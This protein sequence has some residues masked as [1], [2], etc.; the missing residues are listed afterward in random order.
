[1]GH[2]YS[3]DGS[4]RHTVPRTRGGGVRET[5]L[6]DARK[7]GLAPGVTDIMRCMASPGLERWKVTE[8]IKATQEIIRDDYLTE[9]AWIAD[10]RAYSQEEARTKAQIGTEIHASIEEAVCTWIV[11]RNAKIVE[12]VIDV[13]DDLVDRH[14]ISNDTW[15][16]EQSFYHRMDGDGM[17]YGGTI[18]LM[19]R[20]I[21]VDIKTKEDIDKVTLYDE[22]L[23][24]TAFY[25][26]AFGCTQTANL[27][28]G[29]DGGTLLMEHTPEQMLRG[30]RLARSVLT[31][32]YALTE[33]EPWQTKRA[34]VAS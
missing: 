5:T 24:Q 1:M 27:F 7:L 18:D 31:L 34:R 10:V 6:A 20:H 19:N 21:L 26:T 29:Y 17:A 30:L 13:L 28:V 25:A 2:W 12:P 16:A 23:I 9:D 22:H 8:A 4:R 33:L 14:G 32:W 15:V 11:T 3:K